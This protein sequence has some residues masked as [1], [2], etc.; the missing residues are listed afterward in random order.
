MRP[1]LLF[2]KLAAILALYLSSASA[3]EPGKDTKMP[4]FSWD[5]VPRYMHVRKVTAFTP[6]EIAYLASF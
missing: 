3:Q 4:S 5:T 2:P 6:G 1:C